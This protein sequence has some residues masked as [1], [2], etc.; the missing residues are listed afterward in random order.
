M[1]SGRKKPE[2]VLGR[3]LTFSGVVDAG[4]RGI[5]H[6]S[7]WEVL[8]SLQHHVPFLAHPITPIVLLVVGMILIQRSMRKT[9]SES[10]IAAQQV[11]LHDEHGK[12]IL[13]NITVPSMVPTYGVIV[14]GLL[15]AGIVAL[16]W[17]MNYAAPVP[18]LAKAIYV[19]AICKTTDCFPPT[20]KRGTL[21][22]TTVVNAP[23][24][25]PIIGNKGVV[26]GPTVNNYGPPPLP[27]PTI[28][29][30]VSHPKENETAITLKTDVQITKPW[31]FFFFDG[32]IE[33]GNFAMDGHT[34][35]CNCPLRASL[36]RNSERSIGFRL[37][38]IDW[39]TNIWFPRD[40]PIKA[41]IESKTAVNLIN[42]LRGGGD[43]PDVGFP[44]NIR[45]VCD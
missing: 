23:G 28:A 41:T 34:F 14:A 29:V 9:V 21:T 11:Q 39:G 24:G 37:V 16:V 17:I 13:P 4:I 20:P 15:V 1:D 35:G 44:E 30:C 40:G 5:D 10:L 42:I 32:A 12:A 43:N 25:I 19:P 3:V 7:R 36:L 26:N 2:L 27:T 18:A 45:F 38:S 33:S 8:V 6:Y 31:F 22:P